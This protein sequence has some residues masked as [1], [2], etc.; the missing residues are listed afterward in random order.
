MRAA[1]LFFLL[2]LALPLG[3]AAQ[4]TQFAE[5][6]RA[7]A[8]ELS[9]DGSALWC[10]TRGGLVRYD[11]TRQIWR[12]F[13]RNEGLPA[14]NL[15]ALLVMPDGFLVVGSE[16]MGLILG[17]GSGRWTRAGSFDGLPGERVLC[18]ARAAG[19]D[20]LRFWAGTGSGARQFSLE[21]G[22]V[23]PVSGSRILLEDAVVY[24]IAC[25]ADGTV[26]F[27]SSTGLWRLSTSGSLR[28]FGAAEGV[29]ALTVN[30]VE[31]ISDGSL[32]AA[33]NDTVKVLAGEQF[34]PDN[35]PNGRRTVTALSALEAGDAAPRLA[36][37]AGGHL[38]LRDAQ[39]WSEVQPPFAVTTLGPALEADGLPAAGTDGAGLLLPEAGQYSVLDIPG[40]LYNLLTRVA[41]DSRGTVWC[42]S[43][44][45]ATPRASVGLNRWDGQAWTHFTEANS[46]LLMNMIASLNVGPDGRLYLGTWFGPTIIGSGGFNI[47]DDKG[48]AD[49]TDD[50]WETYTANETPLS[51]GVIRGD[52]A[53]DSSGG[54][55]VGSQFNQT[56]PGGLERFDTK[57]LTF[58]SYS[59]SLSERAVR[60]VAAD[61]LGNVWIGYQH[62]G[63]GVIPG[64]F[65][66]G[67]STRQVSSFA[68][69]LGEVGVLDMA[70]DP[71][72]RLW[73][74]TAAK[75]VVLNF[76]E[77]AA[78]ESFFNYTE[79]KP[80]DFGGLAANAVALQGIEAA[81][82]A[83]DDGLW[84]YEISTGA[85]K[86]FNR[87]NSGIAS[88]RVYDVALDPARNL[89][90]TATADGLAALSLDDS[91]E[92][93]GGRSQVI[94]RP[95][96]W[97][98]L[99]HGQLNLE[100]IP[101]YSRVSILTVS[102]ETVRAFEAR[103]TSS[104]VLLWDGAN[105][106]G[107]LCAAG[108]YLVLVRA[109]DGS[110][111]TGK[112]ALIR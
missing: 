81:W 11:I 53:F 42:S 49:S 92:A 74:V 16:E 40:P 82:F 86:V 33:W 68:T 2:N 59:E 27:G 52:M 73:I 109:A 57:N 14:T 18:L 10:A 45:D 37:A 36:L 112:V 39:G 1:A 8:I 104:G 6:N 84:R 9:P 101:R 64:G 108:V 70:V 88:D 12:S 103:E 80:P 25:A 54:V 41:V 13:G 61:G 110:T 23:G 106:A 24:D 89:V 78:D 79:V 17:T 3:L 99:E 87:G 67:A 94:V 95:N 62:N 31:I 71:A 102:G 60:C 100:G 29:G 58:T 107:H 20:G 93:P 77:N 111:L 56:Q 47:L 85:W 66:G 65:E 30:A 15:N 7:R 21:G 51:M 43:A 35:A 19:G 5:T 97:R 32:Y 46:P 76:Q 28:R 4:W 96:P 98:P 44:S 38:Y 69:A 48:T 83:T 72:N 55:W 50:R 63:L 90:W 34:I 22:A 75:A 26:W 105:Q 91:R